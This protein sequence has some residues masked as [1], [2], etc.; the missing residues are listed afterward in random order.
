MPGTPILNPFS[1]LAPGVAVGGQVLPATQTA[2]D[3]SSAPGTTFRFSQPFS[4]VL[5]I[6]TLHF[7][8]TDVY[9]I[10]PANLASVQAAATAALSTMVPA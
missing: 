2:I 6:S 9:Q 8:S 1:F 10:V 3:A 5:G 4:M 7:N